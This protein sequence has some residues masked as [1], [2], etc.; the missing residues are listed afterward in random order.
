MI[1]NF[2]HIYHF[3]MFLEGYRTLA[4]TGTKYGL[5]CEWACAL[6]KAMLAFGRWT[7]CSHVHHIHVRTH[8]HIL[9]YTLVLSL[10]FIL[11]NTYGISDS[12]LLS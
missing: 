1:P 4:P 5:S 11:S 3:A 10:P 12:T 2:Y 7:F 6:A 8:T 9:A